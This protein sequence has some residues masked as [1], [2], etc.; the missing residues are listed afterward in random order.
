MET[1]T[2]GRRAGIDVARVLALVV[3]VAGHLVLAVVDRGG[4]D[5]AGAVRTA[6]L[7][8]LRPGSRRPAVVATEPLYDPDN[9]RLRA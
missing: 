2:H 7:L 5:A 1:T 4:G 9:L 8:G 6:N 3:V